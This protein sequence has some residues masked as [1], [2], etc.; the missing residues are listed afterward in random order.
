MVKVKV[1]AKEKTQQDIA[2]EEFFTA[3][4]NLRQAESNFN[5]AILEY[6]EIANKELTI[7]KEQLSLATKKVKKYMRD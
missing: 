1:K 3:T 2:V 5:N 6:F 7:A 4:R